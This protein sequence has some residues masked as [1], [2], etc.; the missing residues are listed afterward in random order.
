MQIDSHWS[1]QNDPPK[2]KMF[3]WRVKW[4]ASFTGANFEL[5]NITYN[6][7]C[8]RYHHSHESLIH[9]L[10]DCPCI[11]SV[12]HTQVS[13]DIVVNSFDDFLLNWITMNAKI[14]KAKSM[15]PQAPKGF[16]FSIMLWKICFNRNKLIYHHASIEEDLHQ[17]IRANSNEYCSY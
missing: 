15:S 13:T 14:Y 5:R 4:N 17:S 8:P 2:I 10:H 9:A 1:K 12:L 6:R 11:S 3:L 16:T 7:S